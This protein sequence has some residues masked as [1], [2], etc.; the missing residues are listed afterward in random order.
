MKKIF[1]LFSALLIATFCLVSTQTQA[2][3]SKMETSVVKDGFV[4]MD[5]QMMAITGGKLAPMEKNVKMENGTKI[6]RNGT[7]KVKHEKRIKMMNGN[8]VDMLGKVENCNVNAKYY[9]CVD[10]KNVRAAKDG[11]CPKC[12]K[13][14]VMK[15]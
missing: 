10:H 2:Q 6:K 14:L 13:D 4:M 3:T 12:G 15:N 8:C 1:T 5:G 9:T 7:V 11:K